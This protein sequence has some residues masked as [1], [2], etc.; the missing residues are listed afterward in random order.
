M[1]LHIDLTSVPDANIALFNQNVAEFGTPTFH[2]DHYPY[3]YLD[4]KDRI[5]FRDGHYCDHK[6]TNNRDD[7]MDMDDVVDSGDNVTDH[8]DKKNCGH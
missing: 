1:S 3:V 7:I 5:K 4:M 8:D 2:F 6:S